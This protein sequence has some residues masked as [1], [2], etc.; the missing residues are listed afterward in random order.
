MNA[1]FGTN[2]G[3]S[4]QNR[5]NRFET[6]SREVG[7]MT[8]LFYPGTRKQTGER[9]YK[10]IEGTVGKERVEICKTIESLSTRLRQFHNNL[11][12]A[13]LLAATRKELVDVLLI[14]DLLDDIPLILI[15]PG[16][17]KETISHGSRLHPRFMSFVDSDF[18]DV[19]AV[20]EKMMKRFH[21]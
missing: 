18:L 2:L 16:R 21:Y 10:I 3:L 15:L 13:I 14:R 6:D 4:L 17:D 20:L 8:L 11:S 19:Q 5:R 1:V 9:V 12:V 7:F